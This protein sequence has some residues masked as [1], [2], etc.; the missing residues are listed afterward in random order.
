MSDLLDIEA[1]PSRAERPNAVPK[2]RKWIATIHDPDQ[3][4]NDFLDPDLWYGYCCDMIPGLK[5]MV[6][7]YEMGKEPIPVD[8][9]RY[10]PEAPEGNCKTLN[11]SADTNP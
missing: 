11:V 8:D 6:W 2:F 10:N 3:Y 4:T 9:E 1:A 5:Y 7:G